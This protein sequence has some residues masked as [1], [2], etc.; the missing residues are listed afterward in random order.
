M[1]LFSADGNGRRVLALVIGFTAL[2][3]LATAQTPAVSF[4]E[5][6]SI[7]RP[8]D[9]VSVT[10]AA[11]HEVTGKVLEISPSTLA[12][13]PSRGAAG[14]RR[15]WT[16]ADVAAVRQR[17]RDSVMEGALIGA[18][19]GAGIG[20]LG[21][22]HCGHSAGCVGS[23]ASFLALGM[24]IGAAAGIGLDAAITSSALI[25]QRPP[26]AMASV[27]QVRRAGVLITCRF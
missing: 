6:Q 11:G 27:G 12:V 10:D 23:T 21:A 25:Y 4:G 14:V 15:V 22:H 24:G 3:S 17:R 26:T 5:L 16:D 7:V 9:T 19:V 2:A 20:A 13:T 18:V 8:G 1:W